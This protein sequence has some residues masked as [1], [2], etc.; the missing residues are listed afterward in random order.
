MKIFVNIEMFQGIDD[1]IIRN[2]FRIE[3][4]FLWFWVDVSS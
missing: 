1:N 3:R 2:K 4:N